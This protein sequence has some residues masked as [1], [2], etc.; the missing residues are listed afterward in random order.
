MVQDSG[1][2][3]QIRRPRR[4]AERSRRPPP[5]DLLDY[6]DRVLALCEAARKTTRPEVRHE[7]SCPPPSW[8]SRRDGR[9]HAVPGR[10]DPAAAVVQLPP[11]P[12]RGPASTWCWTAHLPGWSSRCPAKIRGSTGAWSTRRRGT[13][14]T[15]Q[16][17]ELRAQAA[18]C[19]PM[20]CSSRGGRGPRLPRLHRCRRAA[21]P[22]PAVHR[23]RPA[24]PGRLGSDGSGAGDVVRG[25]PDPGGP[26]SATLGLRSSSPR[27]INWTAAVG[28]RAQ[29]LRNGLLGHDAGKSIYRLPLAPGAIGSHFPLSGA[30]AAS[31]VTLPREFGA[32]LHFDS[33]ELSIW[34]EKWGL[35]LQGETV[36]VKVAGQRQAQE[37]LFAHALRSH[38]RAKPSSSGTSSPLTPRHSSGWRS[39]ASWLGWR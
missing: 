2:G 1:A 34:N 22:G 21:P 26:F 27:A 7:P 28:W 3:L 37:Q 31:A 6:A 8:V 20:V 4:R 36:A 12:R 15:H 18:R 11:R 29:F 17:A 25:G 16:G 33:G 9:P 14:S 39:R 32:L 5:E 19:L 13:R 24:V 23:D 35:R 38:R 10:P 30:L